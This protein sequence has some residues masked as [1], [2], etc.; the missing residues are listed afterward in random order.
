MQKKS[1]RVLYKNRPS[2]VWHLLCLSSYHFSYQDAILRGLHRAGASAKFLK[3]AR[4]HDFGKLFPT[5]LAW[6]W[7]FTIFFFAYFAPFAVKNK[8]QS[9]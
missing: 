3:K 9:P 2:L 5:I 7:R 4:S 1:V 6:S 8:M